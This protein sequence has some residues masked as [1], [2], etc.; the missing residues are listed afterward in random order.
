MKKHFARR[1]LINVKPLLTISLAGLIGQAALAQTPKFTPGHLAVLQEGDGG[2]NRG[3]YAASDINGSRQNPISINQ[4]DPNGINQTT[5][6]YRVAI[7]TNGPTAMLINGNAGT[8]GVLTL[9]GDRSVLAFAAYQGDILS[10]A[11]GQSTAPSNLSYDRGIGTVDAFGSYSNV[12]RGGGW[13]GI[14]TGKT[15]PRGVATDG[16]GG[17]WGCGNGYGSL[18][19]DANTGSDPIQFQNIALTSCTKVINDTLYASVKNSESVNLYPAG[20]YSFVDFW[21]N[22]DPYPNAASWLQLVIPAATRYNTCVGFD[23]NPQGNVAYLADTSYG[24]QKYI[25]P[26]L[27]WSLAYNLAIPGYT[28][29]VCGTMT[30]AASTEVLVGCFSV[31]VDWSGSNPV[32]YATTSDSGWTAGS[33]YYGNR[34]IRINDTNTDTSGLSII[35]TTNI[36]TTVAKPPGEGLLQLTNV[37]YKSVTFT[38]DLRPAITNSPMSWAASVGD[39]VSFEVG[40][41]SKYALSYQWLRNGSPVGGKTDPTLA[42]TSVGLVDDTSTYQCVVANDYGSVTSTVA[43]L[44]VAAAP[45]APS[46]PEVQ[47]LTNFVGNNLTLSVS[48]AGTDPITYQWYFNGVELSD[49]NEYSG[50]ATANLSIATAQTTDSGTYSVV[51]TNATGAANAA[52]NAVVNLTI[53]YAPPVLVQ[54]PVNATTY[55]GRDASYTAIAYGASLSYQWYIAS[56]RSTNV[57]VTTTTV[58]TIYTNSVLATVTTNASSIVTNSGNYGTLLNPVG[59]DSVLVVSNP[60]LTD[61]SGATTNQLLLVTNAPVLTGI[62]NGNFVTNSVAITVTNAIA[63]F[64]TNRYYVVFTTPGG[65]LT[66]GP[67]SLNVQVPPPHS[68]IAYTNLGQSYFQDFNSLPIPGGGSAEGLNPVHITYVMTNIAAMLTNNAYANA[69]M[70][71][72]LQYSI[73]NPVDFGFPILASGGIGGLGLS[74]KMNGWY[75]WAHTALVFAATKGDQS[76]GAL[77]DNGGIYYADGTPLTGITNRALGLIATTKSGAVAFGAAFINK[78]TNTFKKINLSYIGELWRNNPNAQPLQFGYEVDPAGTNSAL[79]PDTML[80]TLDPSLD[81]TFPTTDST[82]IFDGTQSSNQMSRSVL[83]YALQ[84]DWTP[85]SALWLV[86]QAT[87]LGSAQNLAMDNRSLSVYGPPAV[88]SQSATSLTASSATL[89]ATLNSDGAAS[90]YYFEYGTSTGYGTILAT[91]SLAA[92]TGTPSVSLPITSL[93]PGTTYHFRTVIRNSEGVSYGNDAT[94]ATLT[95]TAPRLTSAHIGS[96]GAIQFNFTNAP[97]A[98]FTIETST[99]ITLPLGL[100]QA[101]GHPTE[102]PAGQYQF[103]SPQPATN[104]QQFYHVR[105]P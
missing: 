48:A 66:N 84:Q 10:I 91:N 46:L 34:V 63:S 16:A 49:A 100:W 9:A 95:V 23:I 68:F 11:T 55:V 94:F 71:S 85:G 60:Q 36:L 38:P 24:I 6:T 75:G 74:N 82:L 15:N 8:E 39:N 20:I 32:V 4:F 43:T 88:L 73:D 3:F 98:T 87:T 72:E 78:S 7:P 67:V 99:N 14:A 83:G 80:L 29:R 76:Q 54:V 13:Y 17:F 64:G 103:T 105:Q 61:A 25:K 90:T 69:N 42:L 5:P 19:Y 21:G 1:S 45:V 44:T 96:G 30:N 58:K 57:T 22:P 53:Q 40:A 2:T 28:N 89:K 62:T 81:I 79:N 93:L 56:V 104:R 18:Y 86:W 27:N 12:Y 52:S 97:G 77:V 47:N 50:T 59:T 102:N 101:I 65:S 92:G 51:A 33:P 35:A 41:K 26:G 31:T 70:A 37:V